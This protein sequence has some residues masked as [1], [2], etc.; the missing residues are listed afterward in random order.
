MVA[1][2]KNVVMGRAE[3]VAAVRAELSEVERRQDP[4]GK[5][6]AKALRKDLLVLECRLA[7]AQA[8]VDGQVLS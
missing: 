6:M 3:Q 8:V 4:A 5:V 1:L 7:N 2:T